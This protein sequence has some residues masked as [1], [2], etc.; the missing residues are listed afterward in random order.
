MIISLKAIIL[1]IRRRS[2]KALSYRCLRTN[3][4]RI[5]IC[6]CIYI[7]IYVCVYTYVCVCIYIYIYIYTHMYTYDFICI[8]ISLSLY[9]YIYICVHL[10][11]H[12]ITY[13]CKTLLVREPWP[14]GPAAESA[15]QLQIRCFQS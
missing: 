4:L 9:I 15:I 1:I 7:C 8:S 6:I 14:C 10:Y 2:G 13:V 12:T 5:C 11:I 3:N